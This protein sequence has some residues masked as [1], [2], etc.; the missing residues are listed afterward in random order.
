MQ[1]T[2]LDILMGL[3]GIFLV[4]RLIS[5]KGRPPLPPGPKG[6]PVIGNVFD[7]PKRQFWSAFKSWGEKYG[8]SPILYLRLRD[9]VYVNLLGQPMIIVN[10]AK[11]AI[12]MLD[13]KSS[14][15]SDRPSLEMCNMT[16]WN[17]ILGMLPYGDRLRETR[18]MLHG[19][20]GSKASVEGLYPIIEEE[21]KK[22]LTKVLD[23]PDEVASSIRQ[24]AG[25][26]I[27]RIAYD[28]HVKEVNDPFV[29]LVDKAIQEFSI[30]TTPNA[31]LVNVFPI[32]RYIPSWFPGA[33]FKRTATA[34]KQ[35]CTDM[36]TLPL[37]Y[38]EDQMAAGN[39]SP[40][41]SSAQLARQ[42]TDEQ[43]ITM[44]WAAASLYGGGADTTV[45]SLHSFLLAMTLFPE[46]QQKARSEIDT[47]VGNDRLPS[48][49]DREHLPYIDALVKEVLR[50]HP[51]APLGLPHRVV[52]DDVHEG[53]FIPKGSM[54]IANIWG[55]LH[56]HQVYANP[57][58]FNP[59]RFLSAPG[60]D[61]EVDP[62]S[63][64]FGFGRRICPGWHNL[65]PLT[66]HRL[67]R[68]F[69]GLKL[70]DASVFLSCAMT[71]AVYDI[72]KAIDVN[73]S[74]ICPIVDFTDATVSHPKPFKYTIKPRSAKAEALI[75]SDS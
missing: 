60:H 57:M 59:D 32:L 51:V 62:R 4:N 68:G 58:D 53:Y 15:Y 45:S 75:R 1:P 27:L 55:I 29:E 64:C 20:M 22:Y 7:M 36:A 54:V 44:K 13:K 70:A 5:S 56:D 48:L 69:L 3:A 25:A 52:K 42:L 71:L 23:D 24:T 67:K 16:A 43:Y 73:G 28:Y 30:I 8:K 61:A 40:S 46:V 14:I 11:Q 72:S 39:A 38:V 74:P 9:I 50:W 37:R 34:Y 10:S 6:L 63:F 49:A 66:V 35:T 12:S 21:S 18:R 33:G 19:V 41:F 47:V 17:E 31:Y 2:T 26:I 65:H